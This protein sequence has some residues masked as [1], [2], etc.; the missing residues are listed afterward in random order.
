MQNCPVTVIN[1]VLV[2]DNARLK[3]VL[4]HPGGEE[5]SASWEGDSHPMDDVEYTP[6]I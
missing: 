5:E 2:R 1:E 6:K 4:S 3:D